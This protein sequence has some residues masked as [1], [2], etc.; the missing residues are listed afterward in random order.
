MLGLLLLRVYVC[1]IGMLKVKACSI[2]RIFVCDMERP[3]VNGEQGRNELNEAADF[4]AYQAGA[5]N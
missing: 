3:K 1:R 5:R 2:Y 4:V